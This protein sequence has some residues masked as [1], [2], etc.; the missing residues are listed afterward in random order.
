[1]GPKSLALKWSQSFSSRS[2]R[3]NSDDLCSEEP[4]SFERSLK[5]RVVKSLLPRLEQ[6]EKVVVTEKPIYL[7]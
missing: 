6:E 3:V 1:M 5:L 2:S 7:Q 4:L